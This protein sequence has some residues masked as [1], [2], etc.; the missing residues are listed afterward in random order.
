MRRGWALIAVAAVAVTA[1]CQGKDPGK[2]A[3]TAS[4]TPAPSAAA[5][6]LPE[7]TAGTAVLKEIS[8]TSGSQNPGAITVKPGDLWVSTGCQGAGKL[9][10]ELSPGMATEIPCEAGK[11]KYTKNQDQRTKGEPLDV[12]VTA[13]EG[14]SWSLLIEQ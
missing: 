13:A 2:P 8:P 6:G 11:V 1:G 4:P 7:R 9:R 12:R 3:A 10:V 5:L 14:M